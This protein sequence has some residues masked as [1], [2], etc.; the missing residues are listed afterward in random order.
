MDIIPVS[1]PSCVTA[2]INPHLPPPFERPPLVSLLTPQST[3]ALLCCGCC[4]NFALELCHL[5]TRD[6]E[7]FLR[8]WALISGTGSPHGQNGYVRICSLKRG[9]CYFSTESDFKRCFRLDFE[10]TFPL[11]RPWSLEPVDY[12]LSF[13]FLALNLSDLCC[14]NP[15]FSP[16]FKP[17]FFKFCLF[18]FFKSFNYAFAFISTRLSWQIW[19]TE[20]KLIGLCILCRLSI[21]YL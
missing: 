16:L 1:L 7:F 12:Y 5:L 14:L 18:S 15:M 9:F 21:I 4:S 13:I 10:T 17:L 2:D 8:L 11:R 20:W 6:R 19:R 3:S